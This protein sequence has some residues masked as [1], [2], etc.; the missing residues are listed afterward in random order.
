MS[1]LRIPIKTHPFTCASYNPFEVLHFDNIGP[2]RPDEKGNVYI[3]VDNSELI[4]LFSRRRNYQI[5]SHGINRADTS[6]L[7]RCSFEVCNLS[8][9][10]L[11]M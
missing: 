5:L 2:L 6:A 11:K 8:A 10:K 7:M 9:I 1:R 3:L 4:H